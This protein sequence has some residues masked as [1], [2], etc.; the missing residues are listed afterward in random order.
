MGMTRDNAKNNDTMIEALSDLDL[1]CGLKGFD[2]EHNEVRCFDHVLALVVKAML[3]IFDNGSKRI[4]GDSDALDKKLAEL[5]DDL[6][7][8]EEVRLGPESSHVARPSN[9]E[10]LLPQRRPRSR[11][12]NYAGE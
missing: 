10:A 6:E 1:P 8:E 9:W 2:G 11:S 7:G 5:A 12:R 3:R 4:E